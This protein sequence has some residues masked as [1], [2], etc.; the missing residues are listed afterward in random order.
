MGV[1]EFGGNMGYPG[2]GPVR[3]GWAGL[4]LGASDFM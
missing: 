4:T 2:V 3:V 1:T